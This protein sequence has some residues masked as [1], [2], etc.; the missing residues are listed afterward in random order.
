MIL[1]SKILSWIDLT[2]LFFKLFYNLCDKNTEFQL[3]RLMCASYMACWTNSTTLTG[4]QS[5]AS[6]AEWKH[7]TKIQIA[8]FT[9]STG[10]HYYTHITQKPNFSSNSIMYGKNERERK[11]LNH[12]LTEP[13]CNVRR[14]INLIEF[15]KAI[16]N[17]C[18][19]CDSL[20]KNF[21]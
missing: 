10:K 6:N 18:F 8:N 20:L 1:C 4:K 13:K 16:V 17:T 3:F 11:T 2:N 12:W 19:L 14:I 7:F 15:S 5:F 21:I 9:N